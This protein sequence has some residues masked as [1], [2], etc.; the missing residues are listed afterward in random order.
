MINRKKHAILHV[1]I[2]DKNG[3]F[4]KRDTLETIRDIYAADVY[5]YT[6]EDT[7]TLESWYDEDEDD[8]LKRAAE[9]LAKQRET[10][11]YDP[12]E[13]LAFMHADAFDW[14][15]HYLLCINRFAAVDQSIYRGEPGDE[16][17]GIYNTLEE[18]AEA[19]RA[20]WSRKSPYDQ[21]RA[22]VY[23]A[24][25]MHDLHEGGEIISAENG[26]FDSDVDA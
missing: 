25:D 22:R 11:I 12:I 21:A 7:K 26:G 2:I 4:I 24:S 15:T 19:A 16:E 8:Y 23:V 18:A 9:E 14:W 13:D 1:A 3:R 10:I 5:D 20:I 17:Y 6:A